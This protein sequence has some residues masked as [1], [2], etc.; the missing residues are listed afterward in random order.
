MCVMD[1]LLGGGSSFSAGGPGKGMYTRLYREVLNRHGWV[2]QMNAFSITG[3]NQ[4]LFG[5]YGAT[6]PD[7]AG[8]LCHLI[9]EQQMMLLDRKADAT[10]LDRARN[11][12][13]STVLMNLESRAILCED[14]G[15]QVLTLGERMDVDELCDRISAVSSQDLQDVAQSILSQKP[16]IALLNGVADDRLYD[17]IADAFPRKTGGMST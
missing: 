10:E 5:L 17:D 3:D 11:Q 12:L 13:R 2:D 16:S 6:T 7:Y 4:G 15:R 9:L 1:T 14:I 8:S